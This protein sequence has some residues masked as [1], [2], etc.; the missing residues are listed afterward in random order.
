MTDIDSTPALRQSYASPT[1]AY[2]SLRQSYSSTM[3]IIKDYCKEQHVKCYDVSNLTSTMVVIKAMA[4]YEN[5]ANAVIVIDYS[6]ADTSIKNLVYN[7]EWCDTDAI[8]LVWMA[9]V[10][11]I[12]RSEVSKL[13]LS[14]IILA[15]REEDECSIC[16]TE[17]NQKILCDQCYIPYCADCFTR[18]KGVCAFCASP[19]MGVRSKKEIKKMEEDRKYV[20]SLLQRGINATIQE[21][22]VIARQCDLAKEVKANYTKLLREKRRLRS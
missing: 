15:S 4:R 10:I 21:D 13:V 14:R 3:E 5:T 6:V 20:A 8:L 18:Q 19:K 7:Q 1:P 12:P 11:V 9:T 22:K 16:L 17:I 2:A